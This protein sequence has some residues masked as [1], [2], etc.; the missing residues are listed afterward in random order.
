[1]REMQSVPVK[2]LPRAEIIEI[3]D[4]P[5]QTPAGPTP[6]AK[7][8]ATLRGRYHWA[9]LL[10]F[11]GIAI[12]A[13]LGYLLT[14]AH[15]RSSGLIRIKPSV[16]RILYQD[17][18]NT[19]M[20]MFD[21]F[22]ESQVSLI[23][24]PRVLDMAMRSPT[25]QAVGRG[26]SPREVSRFREAVEVEHPRSSEVL[27]IAFNDRDPDAAAAGAQAI[28]QA[29]QSLYGESYDSNPTETL[30][31]LE[32]YRK[33]QKTELDRLAAEVTNIAKDYGTNSLGPVYEFKF[34]QLGRIEM[35][36]EQAEFLLASVDGPASPTTNPSTVAPAVP[37]LT[38]ESI[39]PF[40][41]ELQ[42]LLRQRR[43]QQA[44]LEKLQHR[45][46]ASYPQVIDA[47]DALEGLRRDIDQRVQQF[48]Q[49]ATSP[50]TGSASG[51]AP[52]IAS[53]RRRRENLKQ[54]WEKAHAELLEVGG[55]N[56]KIQDR[57]SQMDA[58]KQRINETSTRIEQLR[59]EAAARGRMEVFSTGD[60][61]LETYNDKR[62]AVAVGAGAG[63]GTF[64]VGILLL[65]GMLNPRFRSLEDARDVIVPS[66]R[67]LG[68]LPTLPTELEEPNQAA[69][70]AHCLHGIRTTLQIHRDNPAERVYAITSPSPGAGKTS[71]ALALALSY[72]A[73]G[74]KTLLIDCD[75][76][77][78]GLSNRLKKICR[79]RIGKVL[80]REGLLNSRQ[81]ERALE[82][83]AK[84]R[85][86]LGRILTKLG[87]VTEADVEHALSV[88]SQ[89]EVGLLDVLQGEPLAE[90][91]TGSGIQGLFILPLGAA[92][93]AHA[94]HL[95]PESVSRIIAEARANYDAVLIDTGPLLGSLEAAVVCAEAD[96]SIM[97]LSRGESRAAARKA[98]AQLG[99]SPARLAGVVFNRATVGDVESS[100]YSSSQS[101]R[102]VSRR[103][104][105]VRTMTVAQGL[106]VGPIGSAVA[107]STAT[108]NE[109]GWQ[110][111]S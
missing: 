104:Q 110:H 71:L 85:K 106:Q 53:V 38:A 109:S 99:S 22:M 3:D 57:R 10:A 82:V 70:A 92:A 37:A 59:V 4:A 39:A 30:S 94:G 19:V 63:G 47:Q 73:A 26:L 25:W 86:P 56:L 17:E 14:P 80:T 34:G 27:I 18:Q 78:G 16:Q 111:G 15:Y 67:V 101:G 97:V 52:T 96:K 61:P 44:T 5:R 93:A 58:V 64:G 103:A 13:V 76:V 48:S 79:P 74:S 72:A 108:H 89:S 9:A 90:C 12:G 24:S 23:N 11:F 50:K 51:G 66:A 107:S 91:V 54:M 2:A 65:L 33:N 43:E 105:E 81:L 42:S 20:P 41:P 32:E 1:M 69:V 49:S 98:L 100:G 45:F 31:V 7:V 46:G 68:V 60:K 28:T 87:W 55:N 83:A 8:R 62:A 21:A 6:L 36:L 40:D 102:S 77:G 29:Y 95:S 35:E 88:Q 84:Y 75:I